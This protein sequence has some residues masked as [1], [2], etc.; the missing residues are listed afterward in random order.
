MNIVVLAAGAA[1]A[2]P[3]AGIL[4]RGQV[5]HSLTGEPVVGAKVIFQ[6]D[7]RQTLSGPEGRFQF[8]MVRPGT[9]HLSVEAQGFSARHQEFTAAVPDT[10]INLLVDPELH[11]EEVISVSAEPRDQ[12]NSFQPTSVLTGQDLARELGGTLA[13]T[14]SQQ[15]G[16]AERSFGDAPARPVIRGLDGDRVL[17]LEDG[18]RMGDLSSQSGDHGITVNPASASRIEVVRGPATLIYGANAVGGLVNVISDAVPSEPL[19]GVKGGLTGFLGANGNQAQG[20]A[21]LWWGNRVW[22]LHASGGGQRNGDYATPEGTVDNTQA[23]SGFGS[24]GL[25]WTGDRGHL[26]AN[27]AYEDTRYG[28]PFV[29]EGQVELT[30][31]RSIVNVSGEIKGLGGFFRSVRG[32]YAGRWYKHEEIVAGEVGT[33]FR[34][35]T[36]EFEFLGNHRAY[37]RFSGSIGAR[38][39]DRSFA[40]TG[41]E[42]LSPPVDQQ[43]AAAFVYEEVTFHHATLQAGGRFDHASYTPLNSDLPARSFSTFSG[44]LGLLIQP[45]AFDHRSSIAVSV[46]RT[47]RYPALEELYF[48]GPHP[49]NF[50]FEI[51][52]PNLNPEHA[53]GL[54]L[55]FRWRSARF[56]AEATYFRNRISDYIFRSPVEGDVDFEHHDGHGH[57]DEFPVIEYLAANSL[58]QGIELH[59]DAQLTSRIFADFGVDYVRGELLDDDAPLPRIPPFR[60]RGSVRYQAGAFNAGVELTG[61]AAQERVFGAETPTDGYGLLKLF[62]SYSWPAGRSVSTITAR[63]DNAANTLYR[64]HLSYV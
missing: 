50:A 63:L 22:A 11:F 9:Y 57:D 18:Q 37:G 47:S 32:S 46:A 14:L 17:I 8:D 4:V 15:P 38:A 29:E 62:S 5:L 42:A 7:R 40:A 55:S 41:E 10:I 31:R 52:N 25:S 2:A 13:A 23:R 20:A 39:L 36:H 1:Y 53:L 48:F 59:G 35:D 45:P 34:N 24:L 26:G 6:E 27:Y 56:S 30:P 28:L 51:G 64:N 54:D 44:S 3:Q 16:V 19:S 12:F 43:G 21:D 58:L 61:V 33:A 49:G 60:V